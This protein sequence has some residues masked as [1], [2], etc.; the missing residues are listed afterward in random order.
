MK[1]RALLAASIVLP[2]M[3]PGAATPAASPA[4][5]WIEVGQGSS[6]WPWQPGQWLDLRALHARLEALCAEGP[7]CGLRGAVDPAHE[8]LLFDLVRS[9]HGRLL[10]APP[11]SVRAWFGP[12]PPEP[13]A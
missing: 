13:A 7:G 4:A 11:G 10:P 12:S 3:T 1:R 6:D 8:C 2:W 9:R 5:T